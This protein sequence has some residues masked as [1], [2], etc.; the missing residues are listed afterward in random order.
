MNVVAQQLVWREFFYTMSVNNPYYG[1]ME[2]NELCLNVPW[3]PHE[4]RPEW[5]AFAEARTGYPFIDAGMRQLYKE[6]W[7]HHVVRNAISCF[8]TRGDLWINW[9]PGLR[10]FL[11]YQLD[12]DWSV[13]AGN[14]MWISSSAFEDVSGHV[15]CK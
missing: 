1:E 12:A 4:D 3:Y 11:K 9:E 10:L 7:I 5:Y 2:R 8:L 13:C 14:W 15:Y 6:G